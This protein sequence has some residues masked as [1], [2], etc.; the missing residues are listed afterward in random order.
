MQEFSEGSEN[1]PKVGCVGIAGEV[2]D[3]VVQTH[4]NMSHWPAT[5]GKAIAKAYKMEDFSLIN[6]FNAA[7]Q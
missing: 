5:D 4:A 2:K 3:N 6:D 7:G 1:W